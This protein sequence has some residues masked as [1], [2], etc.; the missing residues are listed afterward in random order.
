MAHPFPGLVTHMGRKSCCHEDDINMM[1]YK[2]A[3]RTAC[4]I[5]LDRSVPSEHFIG[6]II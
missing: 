4:I 6:Q 1:R 3:L 2:L 5:K